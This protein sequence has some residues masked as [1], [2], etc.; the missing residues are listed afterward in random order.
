MIP[1]SD[2]LTARQ[3]WG[4]RMAEE[5]LLREEKFPFVIV[6]TAIAQN[7]VKKHLGLN[8]ITKIL[9]AGAGTGRYSLPLAREGY[10]VT[11]LDI[12]EEMIKIARKSAEKDNIRNIDFVEGT[13]ADLSRFQDRDFGMTLSF[14]APV[15]YSYPN[16]HKAIK[17]LCRVT[18][19][20]LLLMLS[21]RNGLVPFM[22]D[23]ELSEGYLPTKIDDSLETFYAA[24]SLI[25]NGVE[26]WPKNIQAFLDK[27]G[28]SIPFDYAFR[29]DEITNLVTREGFEI[30]EMGGPCALARNIQPEN[31]AKITKDRHLFDQFIDLSM[32]FD[33]DRHNI[34]LGAVN[35][36][37]VAKRKKP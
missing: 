35:L 6:Q 27:E 21:N 37:V 15:S 8:E 3:Y 30:L 36:L 17:E 20:L 5:E 29:V 12:S 32:D 10:P 1:D 28:K 11:H 13:V 26:I 4:K 34:G 23:H 18:K 14:D 25:K 22:I 2:Q 19:N 24:R 33:F 9:D 16:H 31:L 7:I